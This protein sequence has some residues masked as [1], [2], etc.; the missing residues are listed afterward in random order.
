VC[1]NHGVPFALFLLSLFLLDRLSDRSSSSCYLFGMIC[2]T[3]A[4]APHLS[5]IYVV[6]YVC[7]V[8]VM[9]SH[10]AS[11]SPS[12]VRNLP[13]ACM[14]MYTV[15]HAIRGC[16][17]SIFCCIQVPTG[18]AGV[19]C[20]GRDECARYI[21][22]VC[23]VAAAHADAVDMAAMAGAQTQHRSHCNLFN[24]PNGATIN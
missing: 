4:S 10:V 21:H 19:S 22:G 20:C 13:I 6:L 9:M 8:C 23:V 1:V 11:H 16:V 2:G 5:G 14:Y 7:S 15:C 3:V 17:F 18:V 24:T 12:H